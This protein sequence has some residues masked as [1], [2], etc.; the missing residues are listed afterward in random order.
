MRVIT[1][2]ETLYCYGQDSTRRRFRSTVE[3]Q[4]KMVPVSYSDTEYV[5]PKRLTTTFVSYVDVS[6]PGD[7]RRRKWY[8]SSVNVHAVAFSNV[9]VG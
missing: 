2:T 4:P 9:V 1:Y 6:G 3:Y 8:Q 7:A 5:L